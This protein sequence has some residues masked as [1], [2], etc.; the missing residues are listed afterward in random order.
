M[1]FEQFGKRAD[2]VGIENI[3]LSLPILSPT[4]NTGILIALEY[5]HTP[6]RVLRKAS[7][8][9]SKASGSTFPIGVSAPPKTR[10]VDSPADLPILPKS[11]RRLT[12][13][14]GYL[15]RPKFRIEPPSRAIFG[16][17]PDRYAKLLEV[18]GNRISGYAKMLGNMEAATP[19]K[20]HFAHL[21]FLGYC[22]HF[23]Q[24]HDVI[25]T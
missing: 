24:R 14:F 7:H 6:Y 18:I 13:S 15:V 17:R 12:C 3:L 20:I 23:L 19:T 1:I 25:I 9:E 16:G 2:M 5:R 8:G 10:L 21:A 4:Q 22:E 11:A